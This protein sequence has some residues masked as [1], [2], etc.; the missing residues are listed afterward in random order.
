MKQV[1]FKLKCGKWNYRTTTCCSQFIYWLPDNGKR[2]RGK[3]QKT[4]WMT[5]FVGSSRN[6]YNLAKR[7]A[8]DYYQRSNLAAQYPLHNRQN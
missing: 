5:I 3:P 4:W 6:E 7:V 2:S 1:L 8:N